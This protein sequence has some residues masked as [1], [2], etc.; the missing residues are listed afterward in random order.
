MLRICLCISYSGVSLSVMMY[1]HL[2][3]YVR[4]SCGVCGNHIFVVG[5]GESK[6]IHKKKKCIYRRDE[7]FRSKVGKFLCGELLKIPD[8][9]IRLLK[10]ELHNSDNIL[11]CYSGGLT[12][13]TYSIIEQL[14][15][16]NKLMR[17]KC[18]IYNLYITLTKKAPPRLSIRECQKAEMYFKLMHKLRKKH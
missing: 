8:S 4:P 9:V 12:D 14:L 7:Y 10:G 3:F 11:Y 5:Y 2:G 6:I 18:E 16:K 1:P 17:Y 15:I 13:D